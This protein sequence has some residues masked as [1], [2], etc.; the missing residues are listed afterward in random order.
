[1]EQGKKFERS[2]IKRKH[3]FRRSTEKDERKKKGCLK[4]K[5]CYMEFRSP[6][7]KES[8]KLLIT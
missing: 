8:V 6:S 5:C 3:I 2:R 7:E 1:M 4:Y